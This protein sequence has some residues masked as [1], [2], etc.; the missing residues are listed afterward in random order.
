MEELFST[1][2]NSNESS[3]ASGLVVKGSSYESALRKIV[4]IFKS[5]PLDNLKQLEDLWESVNL[6]PPPPPAP[7]AAPSDST[8]TEASTGTKRDSSKLDSSS[9]QTVKKI[10]TSPTASSSTV[11]TLKLPAQ[12]ELNPPVVALFSSNKSSLP[13]KINIDDINNVVDM[14]EITC[15]SCKYVLISFFILSCRL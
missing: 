9:Q 5:K 1:N 7:R 10:K 11:S 2:S 13:E 4:H 6:P 14:L 15:A 8:D 12:I 3:S